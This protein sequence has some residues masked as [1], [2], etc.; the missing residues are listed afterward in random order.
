MCRVTGATSLGKEQL[1]DLAH[2]LSDQQAHSQKPRIGIA[3]VDSEHLRA[4]TDDVV[5]N[6]SPVAVY[7]AELSNSTF[8]R[9]VQSVASP[10]ANK[11]SSRS[12]YPAFSS[13]SPQSL[14][15]HSEAR[16]VNDAAASLP[17]KEVADFLL[18]VFFDIGQTNYSYVDGK[19]L[20]DQLNTFYSKSA[21]LT[22]KDAAWLCMALAIFA[23]GTQFAHLADPVSSNADPGLR[24][25]STDDAVALAFYRAAT[26]LVPDCLAVCSIESVQAFILLGIYAQPVDAAG[27]SCTYFGIA[28]KIAMHNGMHR[29]LSGSLDP[30]Q[31][32]LRRR[33][34]WT[35]Y[36]LERRTNILH[37]RPVS[38]SKFEVDTEIPTDLLELRPFG[39]VDNLH[40]V[41]AMIKLTDFLEDARDLLVSYKHSLGTQRASL[42][43][44]LIRLR[45]D[46]HQYWHSLPT[47]SSTA[48]RPVQRPSSVD[49]PLDYS[50]YWS[51]IHLQLARVYS[52]PS[53]S[54]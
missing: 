17:P 29:R 26:Q 13:S 48:S 49:L 27:L 3:E 11:D 40:N 30:R 41:L 10:A 15:L 4:C 37:G 51:D 21:V 5:A 12:S 24:E 28:I 45:Q 36:L 33:I 43:E 39:R 34:W 53:Y 31:K 23:V 32:E 25:Y 7:A 47:L 44:S 52:R 35:T 38:I 42:L 18:N 1:L 19:T 46:L 22:V 2:S 54:A 50:L 9:R 8:S 20:R 16:A 14:P 6:S